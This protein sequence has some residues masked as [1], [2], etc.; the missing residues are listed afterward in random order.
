MSVA[1]QS[2]VFW[3]AFGALV[4]FAALL[5]TAAAGT[6][7]LVKAWRRRRL[8]RVLDKE[9]QFYETLARRVV[10]TGPLQQSTADRY[11]NGIRDGLATISKLDAK[12]RAT[13]KVKLQELIGQL[14]ATHETL[15]GAL[16]LFT[17]NNASVFF[18]KFEEFNRNFGVLFDSGNVR[19]QART[20]CGDVVETVT[21]LVAKLGVGQ[22]EWHPI[23]QIASLMQS[24]DQDIIVPVMLDILRRTEVELSLIS[25][26][27]RDKE[28]AKALWL[29]E[30]YRFDVKGLYD[31]L[32]QALT[33]M[34]ELRSQL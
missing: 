34:S 31:R 8:Q 12:Q 13:T 6:F 10:A 2:E 7:P 18:D 28:F 23:R 29:K 25:A 22:N 21:E 32:D 30:R 14:R 20:H 19:H 33:Q 24:A 3:S 17:T 26:S 1:F 9:R 11:V 5:G 16:K 15:V 27:I 4:A